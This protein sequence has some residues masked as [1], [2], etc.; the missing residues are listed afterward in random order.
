LSP[1]QQAAGPNDAVGALEDIHLMDI[2]FVNA[3]NTANTFD[4]RLGGASDIIATSGQRMAITLLG[5][6]RIAL[7][8]TGSTAHL[9]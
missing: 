6:C 1:T 7:A 2:I 4:G 3:K 8:P 9:A 5:C